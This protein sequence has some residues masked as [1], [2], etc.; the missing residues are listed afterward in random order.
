MVIS[1]IH[2]GNDQE[3][4]DLLDK[5]YN[6]CIQKGIHI[7]LCCG[8]LIDGTYTRG[9]QSLP[10]IYDQIVHFIKDYP[11]DK[12]ILTFAVAGDHDISGFHSRNQ[13]ILE[14]IRN[15]RHDL[16]VPGYGDSTVNIKNDSLALCHKIPGRIMPKMSAPIILQ[17]HTHMYRTEF[18]SENMLEVRVPSLSDIN[19]SFPTALELQISFQKGFI[20]CATFKQIYFGEK[21]YILGESHYNL[22]ENRNVK[23]SP[24]ANEEPNKPEST[25]EQNKRTNDPNKVLVKRKRESQIEKFNRRY[26]FLNS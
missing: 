15:Y 6:Y 11:F 14:V 19:A 25:E 10:E 21:T 5:V 23:I 7:I 2:F 12:N 20:E 13:D 4:P 22:L 18:T 8:D 3:R 1:D 24:I 26:G 9:E 16:V 17:G